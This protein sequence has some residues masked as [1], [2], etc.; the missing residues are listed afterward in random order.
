MNSITGII[1]FDGFTVN[2]KFW[3]KEAAWCSG[4]NCMVGTHFKFPKRFK[5]L[6]PQEQRNARYVTKNI[7][8]LRFD[9]EHRRSNPLSALLPIVKHWYDTYGKQGVVGYKGGHVEKDVLDRLNIPSLN[10]EDLGCP[11]FNELYAEYSK[12]DPE[13]NFL[14]EAETVECGFHIHIRRP[15]G[16]PMDLMPTHHCPRVEVMVFHKWF[17]EQ[18]QQQQQQV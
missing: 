6:T 15:R 8:R 12:N 16:T 7:H 2:N 9:F 1:D 14:W 4:K 17:M 10:L 18:K 11:K 5:E 13:M 3:C